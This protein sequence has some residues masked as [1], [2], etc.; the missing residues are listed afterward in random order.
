MLGSNISYCVCD[1]CRCIRIG[2]CNCDGY[3]SCIGWCIYGKLLKE[4]L[5]C[6]IQVQLCDHTLGNCTA[7][8]Q[9][10]IVLCQ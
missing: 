2:I 6:H 3:Y 1:L 9:L 8:D 7:L 10:R 5:M 4:L